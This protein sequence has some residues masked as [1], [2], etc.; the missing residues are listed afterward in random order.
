MLDIDKTIG[1]NI[2]NSI[3]LLRYQAKDDSPYFKSIIELII[4]Q[5]ILE[6]TQSLKES[7]HIQKLLMSKIQDLILKKK[8]IVPKYSDTSTAYTNA[9]IPQGSDDWKRVWDTEGAIEVPS[10]E[11]YLP[12]SDTDCNPSRVYKVDLGTVKD[13]F[14]QPLKIPETWVGLELGTLKNLI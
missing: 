12:C 2:I 1:F 4:L 7:E 8:C 13:F 10:Y 5:D 14:I 6:W 3:N 9:N 11:V